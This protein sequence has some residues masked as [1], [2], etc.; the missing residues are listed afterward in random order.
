MLYLPLF[1]R[2][3]L[4]IFTIINS[5]SEL[6]TTL[7]LVRYLRSNMRIL[8]LKVNGFYTNLGCVTNV[9]HAYFSH[10]Q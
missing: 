7:K 8:T 3:K 10:A 4:M 5:T 6:S 1:L 9:P 2:S